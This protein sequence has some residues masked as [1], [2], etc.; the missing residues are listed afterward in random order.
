M[1]RPATLAVCCLLLSTSLLVTAA[2]RHLLQTTTTTVSASASS[3]ASASASTG[4]TTTAAAAPVAAPAG[5]PST[6]GGTT[7]SVAGT[8]SAPYG[9]GRQPDGNCL[10]TR[11]YAPVC[12][13]DSQTYGNPCVA[14]CANVKYTPGKCP[15]CAAAQSPAPKTCSLSYTDGF[16]CGD[17]LTW[18][19]TCDAVTNSHPCVT[20]GVC[21][22]NPNGTTIPTTGTNPNGD[23]FTFA[24]SGTKPA[25][26]A[27]RYNYGEALH[28]AYLF[29]EA[30]RSGRLTKQ[31]L[32]WRSDSCTKCTGTFG[33]DLSGGYY[34]SGGSYLKL[35]IPSAFT[36]T[37]L[38][39][40]L[41]AFK[42]GHDNVQET[43]TAQ[44]AIKWGADFLIASYPKPNT[45]VAV[46]GNDTLDF[47]YY[48]PPEEYDSFVSSRPV[49]YL[50][51]ADPGS[52]ITGEAAAALAASYLA[53][54]DSTVDGVTADYLAKVLSTAES[55]YTF[56]TTFPRSYM[57][58]T[59]PGINIHRGLYP[60]TGY[61]DELCWAALWLYQATGTA[62]YLSQA[63]TYYTQYLAQANNYAGYSF[64]N[65]Q[66][67]PALHVVF[68]S[69][70]ST[71]SSLA[72][73][74]AKEFFDQY[75][76]PGGGIRTT[77]G[78]FALPYH[79]GATRPTTQMAFL[80]FVYA[81]NPNVPAAYRDTVWRFSYY[82]VNYLLG[83]SGRSWV[84]GFGSNFPTFLWHKYSVNPFIDW[85]LRGKNVWLGL[86]R[87]PWT[88]KKNEVP[89][90]VEASKLDT[91][92]SYYPNKF[93]VYGYLFA[94]P[95][96]DDSLIVGRKD[97]TYAE[98]T[99]DGTTAFTGCLAALAGY[100]TTGQA[101]ITDCGL[102]LG[103]G[104]P[105]ATV[106]AG[107]S[108]DNRVGC[109]ATA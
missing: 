105:N 60:S 25:P 55:L 10:C 56:A 23:V 73:T 20:N 58:S 78:G 11:E 30:Q 70:T 37:M 102:D 79:W 43:A 72:Q 7:D 49:F 87:G 15:V 107:K 3:S 39:W 101:H 28:K 104:H 42:A 66:K 95:L 16:K 34:E 47:D 93:T 35:G 32:A 103:W 22:N 44:E 84:T 41:K 97:Y 76:T 83:D 50:T 92:G 27:A 40:G 48:G 85:P 67:G 74:K 1:P 82:Q 54:R 62:S 19:S 100:F 91:E 45:F 108:I 26:T 17:G 51:E 13:A 59:S 99:T 9:P 5:G 106:V 71:Q 14:G 75:V 65:G 64:E 24:A 53:L 2:P 52:E 21:Q 29:F 69:L 98:A 77:A 6:I 18:T 46:I 8:P 90:I 94:A 109:P 12:G 89:V 31:R 4:T 63:E 80:G 81:S 88:V 38:A 68:A 33:E 57:D 36:T 86:D 96:E 61:L